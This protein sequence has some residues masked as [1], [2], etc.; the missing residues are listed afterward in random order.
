MKLGVANQARLGLAVI[1]FGVAL[2]SYASITNMIAYQPNFLRTNELVLEQLK[3]L[4]NI[5]LYSN[6]NNV[7]NYNVL[8][9]AGISAELLE[10][11]QIAGERNN[12]QEFNA[13]KQLAINEIM[14]RYSDVASDLD[15]FTFQVAFWLGAM[16]ITVFLGIIAV[17]ALV[18]R[19]ILKRVFD[20]QHA[21]QAMDKGESVE[22]PTQGEDEISLMAKSVEQASQRLLNQQKELRNAYEEQTLLVRMF[23]HEYRTPLSIIN[24]ALN[25]LK[26]EINDEVPQRR[27]LAMTRAT[28]RLKDIVDVSLN[29]NRTKTRIVEDMDNVHCNAVAFIN[30]SIALQK[31]I[32][33][34]HTINFI[35]KVVPEVNM[36]GEDFAVCMDNLIG[37]ALKYSDNHSSVD[38]RCEKTGKFLEIAI[39]DRGI[40]IAEEFQEKIFDKYFRSPN[41][42]T[43]VGAGLGL[44]IVKNIVEQ[45]GGTIKLHSE[46]GQGSRFSVLLPIYTKQIV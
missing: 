40:G 15:V 18:E 39:Q 22:L 31:Q 24:S 21:M 33:T 28:K 6:K 20:L 30:E 16:F 13:T 46:L 25:L 32:Y 23:S 29:E 3:A 35:H 41:T 42:S 17:Y 36:A 27:L 10:Q 8:K 11:L 45:Y 4:Q 34:D 9:E 19:S 5:Q 12:S 37:N 38:I 1:F 43:I 44:H 26:K 7:T 14:K 2:L